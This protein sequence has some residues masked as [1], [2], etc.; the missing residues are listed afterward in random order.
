MHRLARHYSW[1]CRKTVEDP[2]QPLAALSLLDA[3]ERQQILV[4]WNDTARSYPRDRFIFELIAEQAQRTPTAPAV[5][6][7]RLSSSGAAARWP[8]PDV[9][10][11]GRASQTSLRTIWLT[12]LNPAGSRIA[13]LA[14]RS[15]EVIVAF[16]AILKAGCCYVP[17]D[18]SYPKSGSTS[19]SWMPGGGAPCGKHARTHTSPGA[20]SPI[21]YLSQD[22]PMGGD[23][24][25]PRSAAF[26]LAR[27]SGLVVTSGTT[28]QSKGRGFPSGSLE[29]G[30][31]HAEGA[32]SVRG[33]RH[34]GLLT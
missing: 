13:I 32:W 18:A 22:L 27:R 11:A 24:A 15:P 29:R 1:C 20:V 6:P 26:P 19:W 17:L 28:G 7:R 9:S 34:A 25:D 2:H 31:G 3:A 12:F 4:E 33:G 21:I 16:L 23:A 30:L 5:V 10:R 8:D 14:A